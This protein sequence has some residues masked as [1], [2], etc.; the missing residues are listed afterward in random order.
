MF[1]V[2]AYRYGDT[3]GYQY[4]VGVF[5][6]LKKAIEEAYIHRTFRGGKYDHKIFE[7]NTD[8]SYDAEEAKVVAVTGDFTL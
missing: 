8:E 7:L 6:C 5:S 3:K 4:P 2:M 1:L